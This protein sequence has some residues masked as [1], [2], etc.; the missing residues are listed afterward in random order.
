MLYI[1][2]LYV[3]GHKFCTVETVLL[4]AVKLAPPAPS[5]VLK[6]RMQVPKFTKMLRLF[7]DVCVIVFIKPLAQCGC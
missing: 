1:Y 6:K 4:L 3:K 5:I 7:T 2:Y